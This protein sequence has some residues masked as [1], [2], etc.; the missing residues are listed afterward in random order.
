[1]SGSAAGILLQRERLPGLIAQ[2]ELQVFADWL[3]VKGRAFEAINAR[4]STQVVRNV[5]IWR[6]INKSGHC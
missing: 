2:R 6:K 3:G 1:M 5:L 4:L